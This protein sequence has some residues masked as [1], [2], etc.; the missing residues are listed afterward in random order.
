MIAFLALPACQ[1]MFEQIATDI[2]HET[3]QEFV[4]EF[5]NSHI[6]KEFLNCFE[7]EKRAD[8][9]TDQKQAKLN[10]A[11]YKKVQAA[12]NQW[13]TDRSKLANPVNY[14]KFL[15]EYTEA[16]EEWIKAREQ[17]LTDSCS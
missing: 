12:Y 15:E 3:A 17:Y 16:L 1:E 10:S 5:K 11:E 8:L 6:S 4:D 13:N 14:K 7:V 2:V 9:N